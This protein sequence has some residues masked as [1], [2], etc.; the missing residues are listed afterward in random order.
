[1]HINEFFSRVHS[2]E[3]GGVDLP[4][5][6]YHARVVLEVL[7]EAVSPGIITKV[8]QELPA[9]FDPLFESG[10]RGQMDV[11]QARDKAIPNL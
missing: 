8:R 9:E 6:V 11:P 3:G 10:S 4:E 1:M 5:A 7:Q 2:R